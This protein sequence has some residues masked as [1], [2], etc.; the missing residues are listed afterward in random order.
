M[1]KK[2]VVLVRESG[3]TAWEL[4]TRTAFES[5][6]A[7]ELYAA[8][9]SAFETIVAE[10]PFSELRFNEE[11]GTAAYWKRLGAQL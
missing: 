11:R 7:A 1:K 5:L 6:E 4:A 8:T 10:G 9:S 3:S 2:F